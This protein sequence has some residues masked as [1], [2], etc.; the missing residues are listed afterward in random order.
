MVEVIKEGTVASI[1]NW[2]ATVSCSKCEAVLKGTAK[3]LKLEQWFGTH[4]EHFQPSFVCPRC[5]HWEYVP[6]IPK[7]I[8]SMLKEEDA[9]FRGTDH[10]IY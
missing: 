5:D 4:F 2:S 3:D 10:S 1:D 8:R 6:D 9:V 7:P